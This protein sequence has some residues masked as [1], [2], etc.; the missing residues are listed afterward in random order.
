MFAAADARG[1]AAAGGPLVPFAGDSI[2]HWCGRGS[3]EVNAL[4][5]AIALRT[6]V[7]PR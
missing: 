6:E 7:G 5:E 4:Y 1:V 3:Q 2:N